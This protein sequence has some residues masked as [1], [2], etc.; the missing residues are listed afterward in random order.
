M[1][2]LTSAI[3]SAEKYFI[4]IRLLRP[5]FLS[6]MSLTKLLFIIASSGH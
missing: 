2:T 4:I 3:K 5:G 1:V 6:K